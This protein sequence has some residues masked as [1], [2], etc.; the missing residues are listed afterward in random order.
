M[1]HEDIFAKFATAKPLTTFGDRIAEGRHVLV[2]KEYDVRDT[3]ARGKVVAADFVVLESDTHKPGTLVG[4]AWFIS[5]LGWQG[6]RELSRATEFVKALVGVETA[7]DAS[8]AANTLRDKKQPGRGVKI[9]ANG[10]K[11]TTKKTGN[12]FV[13][14]AWQHIPGQSGADIKASRAQVESTESA[15]PA[16]TPAPAP[17]APPAGSILGLLGSD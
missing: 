1:A 12:T 13:D 6:E 17:T 3:T 9:I 7:G 11:K 8:K 5:D 16:P 4:C 2:L 15:A 14:V 10:I